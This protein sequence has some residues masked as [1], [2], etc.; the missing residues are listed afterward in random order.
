MRIWIVQQWTDSHPPKSINGTF[1]LDTGKQ[2]TPIV[3]IV[4]QTPPNGVPISQC[5]EGFCRQPVACVSVVCV[6][7]CEHNENWPLTCIFLV[8]SVPLLHFETSCSNW[9]AAL[10]ELV[11]NVWRQFKGNQHRIAVCSFWCRRSQQLWNRKTM[12]RQKSANIFSRVI[13]LF[14]KSAITS[15]GIII[16][17]G[18]WLSLCLHPD[19]PV[20]Q[21]TNIAKSSNIVFS[22]S[23]IPPLQMLTLLRD[24]FCKDNMQRSLCT[25][26]GHHQQHLCPPLPPLAILIANTFF[27]WFPLLRTELNIPNTCSCSFAGTQVPLGH[28]SP[29]QK[30]LS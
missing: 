23:V 15:T 6:S 12:K 18:V 22:S 25:C 1:W 30:C 10:F 14:A 13:R 8:T 26:L 4:T 11:Q 5:Y 19:R 16:I 7:V 29:L 3:V 20:H 9:L 2:H 17:I 24:R 21:S 28:Q 27:Y